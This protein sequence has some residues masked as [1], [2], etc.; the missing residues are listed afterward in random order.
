MAA[1]QIAERREFKTSA[2]KKPGELTV[3]KA[4]AAKRAS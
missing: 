3:Y 2:V 4:V 1:L